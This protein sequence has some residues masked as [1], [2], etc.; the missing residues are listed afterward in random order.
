[1]NDNIA[2][3]ICT[4]GVWVATASILIWSDFNT[5]APVE[6]AVLLAAGFSTAAI[7][8]YGISTKILRSGDEERQ[9]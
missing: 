5:L 6:F 1:M 7:W 2:K 9:S 3:T 8:N 4:L